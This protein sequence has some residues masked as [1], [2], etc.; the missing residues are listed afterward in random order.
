MAQYL[1]GK[2]SVLNAIE[3]KKVIE[4]FLKENFKDENV[5]KILKE[6][7]IFYSFKRKEEIDFLSNNQKNQGIIAKIND[8]KSINLDE[9]IDKNKG[10]KS[11]ILI[12]LDNLEDPHNLGA[13]LRI[14]DV[15]N[16]DGIIYKKNNQVGL[17]PTV[18]KVSTGAINFVDCVEVTNLNQT[19][20]KL[21]EYGYWVY[22][23]DM[24]AKHNYF[25]IKYPS[26]T[27]LIVGSE[28]FGIS[29]LVKEN[30]DELIK[31]PMSGHVDSLNAS[32]ACAI[33]V[34]EVYRQLKLKN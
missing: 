20:S 11:S 19:I 33:I 1:Y 30:S 28:G 14:A 6:N 24:N 25:D 27:V 32:N 23:S 17:T 31:I 4:V 22:A 8:Y 13:I 34:S 9:L 7:K 18:A 26:K 5:F 3:A 21:K 2:N 15:F 29:R 12:V 10:N 16:V